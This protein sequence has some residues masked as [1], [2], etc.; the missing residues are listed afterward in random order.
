MYI[1]ITVKTNLKGKLFSNKSQ[2]LYNFI[3]QFVIFQMINNSN[4]MGNMC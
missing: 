4:Q 1:K 3:G 2:I